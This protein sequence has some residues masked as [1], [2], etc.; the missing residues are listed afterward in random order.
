M[1]AVSAKP[2]KV[3]E[4]HSVHM[5][6]GGGCNKI[7]VEKPYVKKINRF[8]GRPRSSWLDTIKIII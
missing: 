4:E 7:F 5:E 1:A 3:L 2:L 6:V 8:L